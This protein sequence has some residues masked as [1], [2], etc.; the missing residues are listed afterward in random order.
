MRRIL[1][2]LVLAALA[3]FAQSTPENPQKKAITVEAIVAPGGLTG[4]APENV[5]WSPDSTKLSFVQRDDTGEH[6]ELWYIDPAA[7]EKKVL[8]SEA[9]LSTLAPDVNKIKNEREK[10]RITR[11]SVAAYH[12]SPDSKYLLFDSLGQ[13]WLFRLESGTAVQFTSAAEP[14]DDPKFSP[15]GRHVAYVRKHNLYVRPMSGGGEK[16]LTKDS[17]ENLLN[18]EVDWV[19]AEEL[20]VRSNYFWSPDSSQ[21]VFLQM[22]ESKVPNYPITDWLP[23]NPQVEQEKYPKPGDSNPAVRLG[24]IS[25]KGGGVKWIALTDDTDIYIPRFG[26]I[27]DGLLWAQVLNRRQDRLDIYFVD[28]K[29]GHARKVLSE[30]S[31]EAW[32]NVSNDFKIL[33]SGDRFLWSSWRDGHTHVYLYKFDKQDPL[34]HEATL[35]RQLTQGDFEML[36][37][38]AIDEDAG[39]VY[40]TAN[41]SDPRQENVYSVKLDGTGFQ[42]IS[43]DDGIHSATFS[44]NGKYY[45]DA[46]SAVVTPPRRSVCASAGM[47][48]H[49]IWQSR[50]VD[51]YGF[52]APKDLEFKAEDGATLYGQLVMPADVP[53]NGKIPLIVNVYGGPA[54]QLVRDAFGAGVT[55]P[56]NEMMAQHGY[57][58]F[59]VDN[60]GTPN[61]GL[62]FMAELRHQFGA[63]ELKDQLASL[64]RLLSQYPMLDKNRVCIWGWSNGGSMT[65][66]SLLHSD[67]YRCGISGAPVTDWHDYDSIYTERYMGPP[68]E[69][70]KAYTESSMPAA[71]DKLHGSLLLIHG[72]SDDNV[73]LQNS[74]QMINSLIQANK[75]F[76]L[77]LYPG[78]TH[79]VTGKER[80]HLYRMM[81][82]F[83][84]QNLK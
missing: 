74:I 34:A 39:L 70:A 15:D 10:E 55:N 16:Q 44:P 1:A 2:F 24:V 6:G 80:A 60:R 67:A 76:R 53:A 27:R 62:K 43:K 57:A 36:G 42:R 73:H 49:L 9:K 78:K 26:W 68:R 64:D 17:A 84:E 4:R 30:T 32:I 33:K 77:M 81:Q 48:C 54:A 40:F 63:V 20:D 66:Y 79:G 35:E 72:T 50:S 12:W 37:V 71:A 22:D 7:G 46:Y 25:A 18:G 65:L 61:R 45:V 5:Q 23:L 47:P 69:N 3:S 8:V 31:P 52:I 19:Y 11:Y 51:D 41:Q 14:S 56:F 38:K 28:A 58:V 59:A 83:L 75:Q 82:D 29:S 21:I 13:L